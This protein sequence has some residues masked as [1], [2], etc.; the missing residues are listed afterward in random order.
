MRACEARPFSK[1]QGGANAPPCPPPLN[2]TLIGHCKLKFA[3]ELTKPFRMT[4]LSGLRGE[5]QLFRQLFRF[6]IRTGTLTS[7]VVLW[8]G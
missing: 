6:Q 1:F 8:C 5:H 7:E 2:E 4:S 3:S